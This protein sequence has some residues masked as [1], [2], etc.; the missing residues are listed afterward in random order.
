MLREHFAAIVSHELKSPISAVQ[1]NLY[2]MAEELS[3]MLSEEQKKRFE[4]IQSRINDLVQLIHTWL[5]V[6]SVDIKEIEKEFKPTS[7]NETI[8]KAVES[9]Q[10]HA[11]RKN[12]E[13]KSSVGENLRAIYGDEGTLVEALVNVIGNAVKYS[14]LDSQIDVE[15][16]KVG[17]EIVISITDTGVGIPKEDIPF[18]FDDFFIS[19]SAP[20][21]ERGSGLGLAITKRIVEAHKGEISVESELGKGST[22]VIQLPVMK[23]EDQI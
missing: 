7:I 1:Q 16:K 12:I 6:I 4:R 14:R 19:K 3:N 10:A 22:F 8:Y 15:A 17:N 13:I 5:R 9:I 11:T 23:D 18:I 2:V 20:K 21:E